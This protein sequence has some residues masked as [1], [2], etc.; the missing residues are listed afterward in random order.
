MA[1]VLLGPLGVSVF[2]DEPHAADAAAMARLNVNAKTALRTTASF[3]LILS[4]LNHPTI[5]AVALSD[6][7]DTFIGMV[8]EV[9]PA[10]GPG[11]AT[12][13]RRQPRPVP[14]WIA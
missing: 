14:A 2:E 10:S 1:G 11:S 5:H 4:S 7:C 12:P 6:T 13:L 3:F 9:M 8:F